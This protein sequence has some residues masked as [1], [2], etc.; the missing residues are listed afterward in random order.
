MWRKGVPHETK[1]AYP[2]SSAHVDVGIRV[3]N[4]PAWRFAGHWLILKKGSIWSFL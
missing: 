3:Q 1:R 2:D 4:R